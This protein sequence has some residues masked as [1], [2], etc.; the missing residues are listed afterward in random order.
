[1]A[2]S[3][4][5]IQPYLEDYEAITGN[6]PNYFVC[7]ILGIEADV[8]LAKGH[9]LPD[10][11]A[12]ASGAKVIQRADVDNTFGHTIEPDQISFL[13]SVTLSKEEVLK[14]GNAKIVSTDGRELETYT[15]NPKA[16]PPHPRIS[17]RDKG[18]E[19]ASPYVKA[20]KEDLDYT[21]GTVEVRVELKYDKPMG[22]GGMLKSAFLALF[23]NLGYSWAL[24][25]EGRFVAE[26]LKRFLE[27]KK[28]THDAKT[29]FGPFAN[30]MQVQMK[31]K[32]FPFDTINDEMVLLHCAE[33]DSIDPFAVSC[34]FKVNDRTII[35]TLPFSNDPTDFE[36]HLEVYNRLMKNRQMPNAMRPA[37][38]NKK[39]LEVGDPIGYRFLENPPEELIPDNRSDLE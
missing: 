38:W 36:S 29:I 13:N 31:G 32:Q 7:P 26:P 24:N 8:E 33:V 37:V 9:I 19:I 34:V 4:V 5:D 14:L 30:A 11:L 20:V 2:I 17:L 22:D 23:R 16:K 10:G 18:N 21:Y 25:P 35:V 39:K 28:T 3:D 12:D 15:P 27:S 1:M 6:R